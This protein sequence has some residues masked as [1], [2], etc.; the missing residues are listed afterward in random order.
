M[1]WRLWNRPITD[2]PSALPKGESGADRPSAPP[3]G[4]MGQTQLGHRNSP[5]GGTCGEADVRGF[6]AKLD[7]MERNVPA[8]MVAE[9]RQMAAERMAAVHTETEFAYEQGRLKA[10]IEIE[11]MFREVA[12]DEAF[13]AEGGEE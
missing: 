7:A 10:Y 6:F 13:G 11:R 3:K 12:R 5:G 8:E 1:R 4:E 2:R 9:W